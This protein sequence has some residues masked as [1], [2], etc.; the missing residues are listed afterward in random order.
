MRCRS[1]ASRCDLRRFQS[2]IKHSRYF[3]I[4][5]TKSKLRSAKIHN[6]WTG[7]FC[8][9]LLPQAP[10]AYDSSR[11]GASC[12]ASSLSYANWTACSAVWE[13]GVALFNAVRCTNSRDSLIARNHRLPV[14]SNKY[15]PNRKRSKYRN[16]ITKHEGLAQQER[17]EWWFRRFRGVSYPFHVNDAHVP[18]TNGHVT[19]PVHPSPCFVGPSQY[20]LPPRS[21]TVIAP[22]HAKFINKNWSMDGL[23]GTVVEEAIVWPAIRG[24]PAHFPWNQ[25]WEMQ[26][27]ICSN[28]HRT[29]QDKAKKRYIDEL[30]T[31]IAKKGDNHQHERPGV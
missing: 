7:L 5:K 14:T 26:D 25:T 24:L 20:T 27:M 31:G 4:W 9:Q 29:K 16:I 28:E 10:I 1:Q 15:S 3:S 12:V 6:R 8:L 30:K 18:L 21:R 2:T 22:E 19:C 11:C 23:K 17:Q 13:R